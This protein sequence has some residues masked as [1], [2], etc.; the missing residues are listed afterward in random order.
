MPSRPGSPR[1]YK[2]KTAAGPI[3][4]G[5]AD[6]LR[7]NNTGMARARGLDV[8]GEPGSVGSVT[9]RSGPRPRARPCPCRAPAPR[10]PPYGGIWGNTSSFSQG[11][12]ACRFRTSRRSGSCRAWERIY[13][14]EVVDIIFEFPQGDRRSPRGDGGDDLRGPQPAPPS[15]KA[16]RRDEFLCPARDELDTR[17]D[18]RDLGVGLRVPRGGANGYIGNADETSL[19]ERDTRGRARPSRGGARRP[20]I[21]G[22]SRRRNR[23]ANGR[24][25]P[26]P[27]GRGSAR[28]RP[29]AIPYQTGTPRNP[30]APRALGPALTLLLSLRIVAAAGVPLPTAP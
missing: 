16:P 29:R 10:A 11:R 23:L 20:V 4:P 24:E 2:K 9:R 7:T 22:W 15:E 25:P 17:W 30:Q 13:I 1:S 28:R 8:S 19:D 14:T 26:A 27:R 3:R 18:A 21:K 6:E 5:R 12:S